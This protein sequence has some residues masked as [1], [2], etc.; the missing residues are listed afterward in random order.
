MI[1]WSNA[2]ETGIQSIDEQ[3]KMLFRMTGEFH[4]A[5]ETEGEAAFEKCLTGLEN[6]ARA[7]FRL[8]EGCMA[9]YRCPVAE[10]NR[11]A[12]D[13][14]TQILADMRERYSMIGF[15]RRDTQELIHLLEEWLADHIGRVDVQ[16]KMAAGR[17]G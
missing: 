15:D 17:S 5:L 8:E 4:A 14:F 10:Q 16:L 9:R 2:Y 13:R 12:H 11:Q 6:Y 1:T 3:H 7:H